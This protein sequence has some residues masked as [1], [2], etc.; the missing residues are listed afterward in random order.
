MQTNNIPSIHI[1]NFLLFHMHKS[2]QLRSE[3]KRYFNTIQYQQYIPLCSCQIHFK[4][5]ILYTEHLVQHIQYTTIEAFSG[6]TR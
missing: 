4:Y 2:L 3:L 1:H 6:R 5:N